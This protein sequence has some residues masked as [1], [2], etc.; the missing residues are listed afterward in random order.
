MERKVILIYRVILM[1]SRIRCLQEYFDEIVWIHKTAGCRSIS[2]S[3]GQKFI[4]DCAIDRGHQIMSM[5]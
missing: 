3:P 2:L 5:L 1:P 4:V